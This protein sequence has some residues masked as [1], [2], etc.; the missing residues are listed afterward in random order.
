VDLST[1]TAALFTWPLGD[2]AAL[3]LRTAAITDAHF[4]LVEANYQRL[5]QWDA[6]PGMLFKRRERSCSAI[7]R[8]PLRR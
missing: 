6:S 3:V 8:L 5:A 2:D 1:V 4:A 7:H